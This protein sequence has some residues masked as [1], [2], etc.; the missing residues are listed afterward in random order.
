MNRTDYYRAVLLG[1][2]IGMVFLTGF[3]LFTTED[4]TV[5]LKSNFVVVD[6]YKNCNVVQYSPTNAARY[7]YFLDCSSQ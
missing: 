7:Q 4:N 2:V 5:T 3:Y 1:I 6:K